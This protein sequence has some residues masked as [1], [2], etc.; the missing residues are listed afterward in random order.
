MTAKERKLEFWITSKYNE[1]HIFIIIKIH[2]LPNGDY[3]IYSR[4]SE[5]NTS[6]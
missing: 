6:K 1:L 4:N 2:I 5:N 3:R